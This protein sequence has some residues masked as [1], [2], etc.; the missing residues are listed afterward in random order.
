MLRPPPFPRPCASGPPVLA[1]QVSDLGRRF[2]RGFLECLPSTPPWHRQLWPA[3]TPLGLGQVSWSVPPRPPPGPRRRYRPAACPSTPRLP[4]RPV[5]TRTR[6]HRPDSFGQARN[7]D[8]SSPH[9]KPNS[10]RSPAARLVPS[11]RSKPS[12]RTQFRNLL[13]NHDA[14]PGHQPGRPNVCWSP[15]RDLRPSSGYD[16]R[17]DR[18]AFFGEAF[19]C[20][21]VI[22][23]RLGLHLTGDHGSGQQL[24]PAY[25]AELV[26]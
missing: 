3:Q 5:A 7:R 9:Q 17:A 21:P 11:V 25:G 2:W 22:A 15:P 8:H 18:R 16:A 12:W 24:W 1:C 26:C 10:N 23:V 6:R 4:W 14:H 20:P 19:G 13:L